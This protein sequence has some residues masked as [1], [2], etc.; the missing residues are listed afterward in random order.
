MDEIDWSGWKEVAREDFPA[1]E[2]N[3]YDYSFIGMTER[4]IEGL[5]RAS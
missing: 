1:K 3:I 4:P 2:P 5:C